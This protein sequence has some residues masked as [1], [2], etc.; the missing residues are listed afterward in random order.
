MEDTNVRVS[1]WVRMPWDRPRERSLGPDRW[2]LWERSPGPQGQGDA[3]PLSVPAVPKTA[4]GT[5]L[6]GRSLAA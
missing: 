6:Q 5:A 4:L 1:P 3:R 2:T